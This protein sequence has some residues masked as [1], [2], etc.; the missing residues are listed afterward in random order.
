MC[1]RFVG[2]RRLAQLKQY[3][4]IDVANV[5]VSPN[6]NIAPTQRILAIA[7]YDGSNHLDQYFWGLV[8]PWAQDPSVGIR[9]IN[10]RSE[11]AAS[12]PSFR[13]AFKKRRCLIPADGFYEW[14]GTKGDRQPMLLTLPDNSPMAFAGLWEVWDDKGQAKAPYRSCTIMTRQA[15]PS[16]QPVHDRMPVILKPEAYAFWL[17][18]GNE[19]VEALMGILQRLIH[20][21]LVSVPVS[22]RV[23]AV[24]NN[25]PENMVPDPNR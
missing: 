25:T 22:R 18:P 16:V 4:P 2:F 7:R 17:D 23:N 15:S 8:P 20:T 1:G 10:A 9:M 11:T 6:Y 12:K 14:T 5:T 21:D 19:D 24:Q 13:A 3:L